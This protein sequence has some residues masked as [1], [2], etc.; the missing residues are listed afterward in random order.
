MVVAAVLNRP[1][2]NQVQFRTDGKPRRCICFGGDGRLR[3]GNDLNADANGLMWFAHGAC[4]SDA[5]K[6]GTPLGTSGL[7]RVEALEAA[8]VIRDGGAQL[9][10][11][12]L[13]SGVVGFECKELEQMIEAEELC[14]VDGSDAS[15]LWPQVFQLADARADAGSENGEGGR[16]LSDGTTIWW[17]SAQLGGRHSNAQQ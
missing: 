4:G 5:A 17:A 1:T 6:M 16:L 10:D 11:F 12:L 15:S 3:G 13:V 9:N 7:R 8:E 14:V 2:A